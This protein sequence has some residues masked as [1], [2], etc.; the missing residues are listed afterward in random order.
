[1]KAIVSVSVAM[2]IEG[3]DLNEIKNKFENY[4][5]PKEMEYIDTL[6]VVDRETFDDLMDEWDKLY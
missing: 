4:N 3:K 5:F 6:S 1:M 2:E